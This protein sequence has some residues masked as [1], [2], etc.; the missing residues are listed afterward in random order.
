[1]LCNCTPTDATR[2]PPAKQH[3]EANIAFRGPAPSSQRPK[4]KAESPS[5]AMATEKIQPMVVSFQSPSA[6]ALMPISVESG[7][8][9]TLKPYA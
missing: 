4:A 8:L 9:K 7:R 6:G 2:K 1:M 3:A 5:A